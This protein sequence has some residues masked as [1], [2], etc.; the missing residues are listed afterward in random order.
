M[1]R[2]LRIAPMKQDRS[3]LGPVKAKASARCAAL[4]VTGTCAPLPRGSHRGEEHNWADAACG[5][6]RTRNGVIDLA[7]W[8]GWFALDRAVL[9]DGTRRN[10]ADLVTR[11]GWPC[12][13]LRSRCCR[14]R[15]VRMDEITSDA[16]AGEVG[17]LCGMNQVAVADVACRPAHQMLMSE[18]RH[19]TRRGPICSGDGNM[20]APRYR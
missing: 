13:C 2:V 15:H 12:R 8:R 18:A 19:A 5:P 1:I 17:G 9:C 16:A 3:V 14:R 11:C 20:P 4:R 7:V 10:G 6:H